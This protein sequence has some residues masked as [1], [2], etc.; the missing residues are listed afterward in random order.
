MGQANLMFH[1]APGSLANME[2]CLE[3]PYALETPQ[4]EPPLR[5][6]MVYIGQNLGVTTGALPWLLP[7]PAPCSP[8]LC[9]R[10]PRTLACGLACWPEGTPAA[11][12]TMLM[13]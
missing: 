8:S 10:H 11:M 1:Y 4:F 2:G 6:K 13:G 12:G 9:A 5:P 3:F 7:E